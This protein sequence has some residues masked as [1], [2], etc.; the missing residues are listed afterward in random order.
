MYALSKTAANYGPLHPVRLA[1]R[2]WNFLSHN[3]HTDAACR[4]LESCFEHRF[5]RTLIVLS[6]TGEQP[7]HDV[8]DYSGI[9]RISPFGPNQRRR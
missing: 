1:R 2:V 4:C 7:Y 9:V 3:E 6:I 8:F 5:R